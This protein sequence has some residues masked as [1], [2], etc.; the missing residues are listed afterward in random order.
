MLE[1]RPKLMPSAVRAQW[2]KQ[3]YFLWVDPEKAKR[4]QQKISR[5]KGGLEDNLYGVM[6][7]FDN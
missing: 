1:T 2:N 4:Y 7:N 5:Q 6:N 3:F